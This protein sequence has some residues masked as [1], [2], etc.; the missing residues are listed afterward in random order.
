LINT[1]EIATIIYIFLNGSKL[2][3]EE[4]IVICVIL[5]IRVLSSISIYKKNQN[6][7]EKKYNK[8][9]YKFIILLITGLPLFIMLFNS[10]RFKLI[11]NII[12]TFI[13]TIICLPYFRIVYNYINKNKYNSSNGFWIN[14]IEKIICALIIY[15][16][17]KNNFNLTLVFDFI[18]NINNSENIDNKNINNDENIDNKNINNDE[19][20]NI[21]ENTDEDESEDENNSK[22]VLL[23]NFNNLFKKKYI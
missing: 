21:N 14:I 3:T 22:N 10:D 8:N 1:I 23:N 6:N 5:A 11:D 20:K 2:V 18:K 16:I 19:D 7:V 12:L 17:I 15:I 4:I 9:I 13:I